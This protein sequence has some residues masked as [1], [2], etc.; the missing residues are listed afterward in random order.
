MPELVIPAR[1][2][3][4]G[5]GMEVKRI[6]PFRKRRMVGPFIF[7][8]HAGPIQA[9]PHQDLSMDVL[10]HP[11]IGLSTVTYLLGGEVTHRDSIGV[12]QVIQ[13]GAVNWMT[14]GKGISHSERFEDPNVL[15]KGNLEMLQSWVALPEQYEEID[16]SFENYQPDNLPIYTDKGLWMRLIAGNAYGL[17]NRVKTFSPLFYVHVEL[18]AGTTIELPQEHSER[19]VYLVKGQLEI[20]HQDYEHGQMIV[21]DKVGSD[22]IIKA[23]TNVT[24][25]MMGGE[26]LG[27]RFIWWNFVSSRKE[28]IEE[29]KND[30][31]EGR[32]DLPPMDNKEFVPLPEDRSRPAEPNKLS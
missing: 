24:L 16:P 12:E 28:R 18:E 20:S 23:K 13:P 3:F 21:F 27:E 8:D 7:L 1:K 4:I 30:W 2:A 5:P 32:I 29:A 22:P 14:A 15:K 10:P 17:N 11:H 26:P 31:K 9:Q 6:L 19:A 25:M